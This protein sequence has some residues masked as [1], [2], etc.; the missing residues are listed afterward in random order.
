MQQYCRRLLAADR[1]L[2]L[3]MIDYAVAAPYNYAG[4]QTVNQVNIYLPVILKMIQLIVNGQPQRIPLPDEAGTE[5]S[6]RDDK[7]LN[8]TQL[9]EHMG[10]YGK[11]IAVERNG[12]I[13]PR[14]KFN[15]P[16]LVEGD[17]LEIVV[18][19]GGG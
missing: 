17:R 9:L 19:V 5:S 2:K 18:A 11:R 4:S 16:M 14:S 7:I 1:R 6:K 8:I 10:L 12:E 3:R 15:Q 13:V